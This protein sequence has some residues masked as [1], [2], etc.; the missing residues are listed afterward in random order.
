MRDRISCARALERG[1]VA[2]GGVAFRPLRRSTFQVHL[3][4]STFGRG[5]WFPRTGEALKLQARDAARAKATREDWAISDMLSWEVGDAVLDEC[6]LPPGRYV[7]RNGVLECGLPPAGYDDDDDDDDD[8]NPFGLNFDLEL[9]TGC[10]DEIKQR[11]G[12]EGNPTLH[13]IEHLA[14]SRWC[15]FIYP[16]RRRRVGVPWITHYEL[17]DPDVL[18]SYFPRPSVFDER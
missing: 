9:L 8:E 17:G 2:R 7:L 14:N 6:G 10:A 5:W 1:P 18:D 12:D 11:L 16:K 13:S 4:G 3:T 15:S